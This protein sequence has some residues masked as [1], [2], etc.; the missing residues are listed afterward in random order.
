MVEHPP[1]TTFTHIGIQCAWNTWPQH[2]GFPA[3]T[4]TSCLGGLVVSGP[5]MLEIAGLRGSSAILLEI[6]RLLNTS[7]CLAL[8]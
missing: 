1:I 2:M 7:I 8:L 4:E 5:V 3:S 6:S